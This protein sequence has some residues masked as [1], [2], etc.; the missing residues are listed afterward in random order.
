[1]KNMIIFGAGASFGSGKTFF[2]WGDKPEE[3]TTPLGKQLFKD[4]QV[5]D[6]ND[7]G[8][9]DQSYANIFKDDFEKGMEALANNASD[10]L[11]PLQRKMASYFF[12]FRLNK[13]NL[14]MKLAQKMKASRWSGAVASL[15]Y[16]RLI[17]VALTASGFCVTCYSGI[18]PDD[19]TNENS[20]ELCLPHGC[21][22]L[23]CSVRGSNTSVSGSV[24]TEGNITPIRNQSE[25]QRRIEE[26]SLP[27]VM[28]YFDPKKEALSGKNFI[29]GQKKRL[30]TLISQAENIAV[31]G[32]AVRLDDKHIWDPLIQ[33]KGR[34]IYYS[35]NSSDNEFNKIKSKRYRSDDIV[36]N[37]YFNEAF[38]EVCNYLSIV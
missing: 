7:W 14:Y 13:S 34:L 5:F 20:I 36:I 4:L 32:V 2:G 22:H 26:D 8:K 31:I 16:E 25:F 17:E 18:E 9:L 3:K 15:N 19:N 21:C 30:N 23:F 12:N 28:C 24:Y 10:R 33:T 6:P 37:K 27:P 35:G 1:M 11:A 38:D 29:D